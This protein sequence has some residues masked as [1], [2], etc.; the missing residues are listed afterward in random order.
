[1]SRVQLSFTLDVKARA[2]IEYGSAAAAIATEMVWT[3]C[4]CGCVVRRVRFHEWSS[5]PNSMVLLAPGYVTGFYKH[6]FKLG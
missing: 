2:V 4:P 1:M 6:A 5:V 3:A